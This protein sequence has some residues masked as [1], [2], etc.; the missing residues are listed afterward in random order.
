MFEVVSWWNGGECEEVE[1]T[2]ATYEEAY[3]YLRSFD[4]E[5]T[6]EEGYEIREVE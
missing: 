6:C 4:W 2:F 5:E 3:A 1:E